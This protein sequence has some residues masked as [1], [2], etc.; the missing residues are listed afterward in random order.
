VND[1]SSGPVLL[2]SLTDSIEAFALVHFLDAQGLP[3]ILR[4]RPLKIALGEIPFVEAAAE[5]YLND[6]ARLEEAK[7][8]IERYRAGY[9]GTFGR[10][11]TCSA[12]GE[13]HE[14]QFGA[15]WRCGA[16]RPK[17]LSRRRALRRH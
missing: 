9:A 4:E 2:A 17:S 1:I 12:C 11:W 16:L 6:P 13:T 15:C 8:L 10:S 3:V 7:R 5:L 14:P